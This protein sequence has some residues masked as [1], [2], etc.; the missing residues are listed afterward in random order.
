MDPGTIVSILVQKLHNLA[1]G[2][3]S[4]WVSGGTWGGSA[5]LSPVG[6][7]CP[8]RLM[9]KDVDSRASEN[10]GKHILMTKVLELVLNSHKR[11]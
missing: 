8:R 1:A 7:C 4:A 3:M 6:P 10:I 9:H 5:Q 11:F 2:T